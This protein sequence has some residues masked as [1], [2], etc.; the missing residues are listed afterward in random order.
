MPTPR[1][2]LNGRRI[3]VRGT[4]HIYLVDRGLK[5]HIPNPGTYNNLFKDWDDIL[6]LDASEFNNITTGASVTNAALL[7][8][9]RGRNDIYLIESFG[10]RRV[11]S[12]AVMDAFGLDWGKVREVP[13][14]AL[15]YALTGPS[16][17]T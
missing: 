3:K 10:K 17:T 16:I 8:R 2:D 5:R 4:T 7:A 15:D 11:V 13:A 14:L 12:P 1:P 6:E 9:G